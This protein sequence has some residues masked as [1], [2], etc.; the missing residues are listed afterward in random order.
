MWDGYEFLELEVYT[1]IDIIIPPTCTEIV[2]ILINGNCEYTKL[3]GKE[4][5]RLKMDEVDQLTLN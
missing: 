1:V 2:H 4:E 3:H 5:L